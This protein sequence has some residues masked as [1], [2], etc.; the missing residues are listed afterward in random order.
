MKLRRQQS[1]LSMLSMLCIA[2]MV[3]FFVMCG[4][5]MAPSYFEYLS[6]KE[7][8]AKVAE[9]HDPEEQNIAD[10]RRRIAN[11]LNTNQVYGIKPQDVDVYRKE[12]KTYIDAS[13]EARIPIMWRIDAVLKFDDLKYEAGSGLPL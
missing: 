10:I 9:E 1:G 8:M 6:V 5:K 13:Y 7:I 2:V 11:L 12:G 3:G 4:I